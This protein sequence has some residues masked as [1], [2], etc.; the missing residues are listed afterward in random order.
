M[1]DDN[2]N[3]NEVDRLTDRVEKYTRYGMISFFII[4]LLLMLIFISDRNPFVPHK[5]NEGCCVPICCCVKSD[6][7]CTDLNQRIIQLQQE[8][9]EAKTLAA[10]ARDIALRA[11]RKADQALAG[12]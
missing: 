7:N 5:G 8:V 6:L 2:K 12:N 10:E 1:D 4:L 3:N 9:N 11:E